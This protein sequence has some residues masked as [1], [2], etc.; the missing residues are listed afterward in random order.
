MK[1]F[2]NY[3]FFLILLSNFSYNSQSNDLTRQK[4][5]EK[6]VN[7]FQEKEYENSINL[8]NNILLDDPS[9]LFVQNI[10]ALSL[11]NIGKRKEAID[12]LNSI[13]KD[14]PKEGYLY[15]NL[16]NIF[17]SDGKI[18]CKNFRRLIFFPMFFH[19]TKKNYFFS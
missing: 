10:L 18:L 7:F 4:E 2:I 14:H 11:K 12:V 15:S 16:G 17:L 3:I 13:I 9:N 6:V 5:I 1:T 19:M 8:A